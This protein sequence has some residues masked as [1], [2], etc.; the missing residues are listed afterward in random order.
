MD[1]KA[2][3]LDVTSWAAVA[4]S[5]PEAMQMDTSNHNPQLLIETLILPSY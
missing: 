3:P 5:K 2:V 1:A 4:E